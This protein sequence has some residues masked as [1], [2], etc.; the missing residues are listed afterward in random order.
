MTFK[1]FVG[2]FGLVVVCL[3]SSAQ[4]QDFFVKT[5]KKETEQVKI[6]FDWDSDRGVLFRE[7]KVLEKFLVKDKELPSTWIE[8]REPSEVEKVVDA[9][10][11]I[12]TALM[13]I[14]THD[15]YQ[16]NSEL[17]MSTIRGAVFLIFPFEDH[18]IYMDCGGDHHLVAT[19]MK[20]TDD[21]LERMK[22]PEEVRRLCQEYDQSHPNS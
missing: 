14:S 16:I 15:T 6:E 4:A 2:L 3:S 1:R 18:N 19:S 5:D 11:M 12:F 9:A 8:K 20:P 13:V 22:T 21:I 7:P 17:R 10:F